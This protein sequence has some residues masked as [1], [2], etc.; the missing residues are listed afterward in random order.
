M[1]SVTRKYV[2]EKQRIV[3]TEGKKINRKR[4]NDF[5]NDFDE[6]E[7]YLDEKKKSS[8]KRGLGGS[9]VRCE[10]NIIW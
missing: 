10:V 2:K 4:N 3:P 5:V 9:V 8:K 7:F 1:V 6:N